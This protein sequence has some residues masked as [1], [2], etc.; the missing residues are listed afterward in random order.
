M[1]AWSLLLYD[2]WLSLV[3]SFN[4]PPK[5][6]GLV[7][8]RLMPGFAVTGLLV[9]A[10]IYNSQHYSTTTWKYYYSYYV[11]KKLE[12]NNLS[13]GSNNPG[14]S[15]FSRLMYY[16]TSSECVICWRVTPGITRATALQAL[17]LLPTD[18]ASKTTICCLLFKI[19]LVENR[20]IN[21]SKILK[22][23]CVKISFAFNTSF[24][25]KLGLA[26]P[27]KQRIVK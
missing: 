6:S 5:L 13:L 7:Q 3:C 25:Q 10:T 4:A 2:R 18:L 21:N 15:K 23:A 26:S 22:R 9:I 12:I 27:N 16:L 20:T 17:L 14:S 24:S 19:S 11:Q 8:V 1:T